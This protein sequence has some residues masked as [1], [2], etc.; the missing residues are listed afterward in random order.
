MTLRERLQNFVGGLSSKFKNIDDDTP[1]ALKPLT[2]RIEE[3]GKAF[4]TGLSF[5]RPLA[6]IV[7][8]KELDKPS[9]SFLPNSPT[10]Q[11]VIDT[12]KQTG[13]SVVDAGV[14]AFKKAPALYGSLK[15]ALERDSG[16][17]ATYAKN[18][19][20]AGLTSS[21]AMG[22]TS[23]EEKR[24]FENNFPLY[25][26]PV[27]GP[28]L[29][30]LNSESDELTVARG[31]VM[32][33]EPLSQY[34]KNMLDQQQLD[35][36][37]GMATPL[38]SSSVSKAQPVISKAT[39]SL[40]D[41]IKDKLRFL[42]RGV[43]D[44]V[45]GKG[46]KPAQ[47]ERVN[48][49]KYQELFK[50]PGVVKST[51]DFVNSLGAVPAKQRVN[52]LDYMRT[53]EKI[54]NKIGLGREF[55]MLRSGYDKYVKELPEEIDRITGW[56]KQLGPDGDER[57]FR[58]LDGEKVALTPQ[59]QQIGFEIKGYLKGWAK[60]LGLPE[61]KQITNYITHI[62]ED[63]GEWAE[64]D[65]EIAK[66]IRDKV[67][68]SV[69]DPFLQKRRGGGDYI[70]STAR[71][72]DAYVKRG[73]RKYNLDPAL[74]QIKGAADNLEESQFQYVKNYID[75]VNLRPTTID[76]LLDNLIRSSPIGYKFGPRP[77]N[78][79][80]S[81]A[82][83]AVYRGALGLNVKT[84]LNNL[85]QASNTYAEL[86][87]RWTLTGYSKV[88][89]NLAKFIRNAP[90]E[91]DE[92]GILGQDMIQDRTLS[93]TKK[94]LQAADEVL[95]HLFNFAEKVNRGAAFWG[96][97]AK[98]L[99]EG[100]DEALAIAKAKDVVG[101]TQFRFGSIDTPVALQSDV[102]KTLFQFLTYTVKQA[103]FLGE[104][105]T[106]KDVAGIVRYVAATLVFTQ[107]LGKLWGMEVTDAIPT[108]RFGAPPTLQLPLGVG[109]AV[110]QG[111]DAYGNPLSLKDRVLNS[112]LTKGVLNYIP[113]GAQARKTIMGAQA[114]NDGGVY[115]KT[116]RLR[117]PVEPGLAP[118]I[119]GPN[120]SETAKEYYDSGSVMGEKQTARYKSLVDGGMEPSRAYELIKVRDE[121]D[122]KEQGILESISNAVSGLFG[123]KTE[124]KQS[125]EQSA[126]TKAY[127][128][129]IESDEQATEIRELYK[130]RLSDEELNQQLSQLGV[131]KEEADVIIMK[132]LGV[133]N[134]NRGKFIK[135][136]LSPLQGKEYVDT[137]LK[138]AEQGVLSTGVVDEW[139]SSDQITKEQADKLKK[140]IKRAKGTETV[141]KPKAIKL[142][143]SINLPEYKSTQI[144]LPPTPRLD[145]EPIQVR[146]PTIKPPQINR[147]SV[148]KINPN[149]QYSGAR[150]LGELGR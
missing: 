28:A 66:M 109:Q 26:A 7:V 131:T 108:M 21:I 145:I 99:A 135:E 42:V 140:L 122:I 44:L 138:L 120:V 97:K 125:G 75:R 59:E 150:T 47:A 2:Q 81:K 50:Q 114:I 56:Y 8:K 139:L 90:T 119:F 68:G 112:N 51:D 43:D 104:K 107:T 121:K 49:Q 20:A 149:I 73:V 14:K 29:K 22:P 71:A 94:M 54:L 5:A 40:D 19:R 52:I 100:A 133:E 3:T 106:Q 57:V 144:K 9:L 60:K 92:V 89:Q 48:F 148:R 103:E 105:V 69:Y 86:G 82:R 31:K 16:E 93:S 123:K 38:N 79:I 127:M 146:R 70:R 18:A 23:I 27:V 67:S 91:L 136:L 129:E 25:K 101:K 41:V 141:K 80:T 53:P 102:A 4:K 132:A 126:L 58:W 62:F 33:G 35:L 84:A 12:Y 98:F 147:V 111:E 11:E 134:G 46:M 10:R 61:D 83:K 24:N 116:G 39:N 115:S 72:L 36:V 110:T 78:V 77:T 1:E 30:F 88:A 76:N 55:Q 87:E 128:N 124:V 118:L 143:G 117:F 74:E 37:M 64:L 85:T 45:K 142:S 130:L 137:V 6:R 113:A 13:Q 15:E 65:P 95:F 63:S 96:A 17:L 34:E 32:A